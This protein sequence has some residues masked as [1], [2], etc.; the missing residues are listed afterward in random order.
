MA[1]SATSVAAQINKLDAKLGTLVAGKLA[2]VIVV[3]GDP[4]ADLLV[5]ANVKMTYVGGRR[6]V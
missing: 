4:L 5:L 6:L 3:D 2:D 1:P